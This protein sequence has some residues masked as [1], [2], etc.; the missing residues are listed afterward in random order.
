MRTHDREH[1]SNS[2][3]ESE[4]IASM[5]R[6]M[7]EAREAKASAARG[8]QVSM[9]THPGARSVTLG[10]Y[11][12]LAEARRVAKTRSSGRR[13]L[14]GQD[15]RIERTDGQLVEYTGPAR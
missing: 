12:T 14:V 11:S 15:V 9:P 3:E 5:A 2:P 13:D 8:Y 10:P 7:R 6:R 4:A 1:S